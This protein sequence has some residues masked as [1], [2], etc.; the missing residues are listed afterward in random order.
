M[1]DRED[2]FSRFH[3]STYSYVRGLLADVLLFVLVVGVGLTIS[4]LAA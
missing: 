3:H 1:D 4:S 2:Y